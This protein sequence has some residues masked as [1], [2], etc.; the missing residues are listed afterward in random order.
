MLHVMLRLL[1]EFR[2]I[3]PLNVR[4]RGVGSTAA[5]AVLAINPVASDTVLAIVWSAPTAWKLPL[6]DPVR[7]TVSA[8]LPKGPFVNVAFDAVSVLAPI[9]TITPFPLNV[10]PPT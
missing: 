8:P 2:V 9:W 7:L 4:L 3:G 1:V 10:V 5:L 6:F